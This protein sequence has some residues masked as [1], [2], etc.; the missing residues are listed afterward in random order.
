L[1]D[2]PRGTT[3]VSLAPTLDWNAVPNA[4]EYRVQVSTASDFSSFVLNRVT[5]VSKFNVPSG[6]LSP[7]TRYYWRVR[8]MAAGCSNGPWSNNSNF[9]TGT[10]L[11]GV[12]ASVGIEGESGMLVDAASPKLVWD[13]AEGADGYQIQL[14]NDVFFDRIVFETEV[15]DMGF[16]P[17][18]ALLDPEERMFARVRSKSGTAY[19][20]WSEAVE[21]VASVESRV[22]VEAPIVDFEWLGNYPN[23]SRGMTTLSLRTPKATDVE[24]AIV[25]V[26]GSIVRRVEWS[27]LAAGSHRRRIDI[28][29]MA[30]GLY[31]VNYHATSEEGDVWTGVSKV[32]IFK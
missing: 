31:L 30:A 27:G 17:D 28:S 23:P 9:K 6:K 13:A 21:L 26:T 1:V 5:T 20:P 12:A 3:G 29:D 8:A 7:N 32:V 24:V 2:P 4:D 10:S 14:S 16:A 25:T 19:G 11:S 18:V 15:M 22:D